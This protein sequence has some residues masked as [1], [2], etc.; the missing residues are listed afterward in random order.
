MQPEE[1]AKFH[2]VVAIEIRLDFTSSRQ[3][4]TPMFTGVSN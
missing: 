3:P 4:R 2:P 1:Q